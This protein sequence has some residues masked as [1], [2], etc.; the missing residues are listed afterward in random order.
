MHMQMAYSD[1]YVAGVAAAFIL[2]GSNHKSREELVF[3]A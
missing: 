3:R 2:T 1:L